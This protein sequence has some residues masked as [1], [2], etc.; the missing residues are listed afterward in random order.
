VEDASDQEIKD[1][2][3]ELAKLKVTCKENDTKMH[4]QQEMSALTQAE[5]C[6]WLCLCC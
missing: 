5:L 4:S 3:E 6:D 1:L 2:H